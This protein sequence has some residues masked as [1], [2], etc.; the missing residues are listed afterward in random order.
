MDW[1]SSQS[2]QT[3]SSRCSISSEPLPTT[4][5]AISSPLMTSSM[6]FSEVGALNCWRMMMLLTVVMW[7]LVWSGSFI[8]A[9]CDE[10]NIS[11][12]LSLSN[13]EYS[14]EYSNEGIV[15]CGIPQGSILGPLLFSFFINDL[16]LHITSNKVNCD[17]FADDTSLNTSDK[18]TDTVQKELQRSINE[19]SDW[20]NNNAM[21]LLHAKTKSMLVT[22]RQKHQ[23]HPLHL[24]LSLKESYWTSSWAPAPWRYYWWWI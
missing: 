12:S 14:N 20:C 8:K 5:V 17:M 11:L 15:R 2:C 4:L 23:L 24:N 19:A 7:R 21:S 18:D 9:V 10:H 22:T 6:E 1:W 3:L 13:E 16:P